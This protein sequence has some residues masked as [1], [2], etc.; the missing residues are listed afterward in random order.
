VLAWLSAIAASKIERGL[1]K[2][3]S[4]QSKP[5][6]LNA[7]EGFASGRNIERARHQPERFGMSSTTRSPRLRAI[8]TAEGRARN[9]RIEFRLNG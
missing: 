8:D 3:G 1:P 7:A 9:R 4:H 2:C 5:S 6:G